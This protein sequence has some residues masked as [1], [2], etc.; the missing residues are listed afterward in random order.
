MKYY[1][2]DL[3]R[4]LVSIGEY[5]AACALYEL[6]LEPKSEYAKKILYIDSFPESSLLMVLIRNFAWSNTKEG[7]EYWK[8]LNT[9]W[10]DGFET[11]EEITRELTIKQ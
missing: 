2:I 1:T 6:I 9:E 4:Y 7:W 3:A 8:Y 5:E 11:E 10:L